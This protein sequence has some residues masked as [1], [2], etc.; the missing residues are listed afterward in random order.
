MICTCLIHSVFELLQNRIHPAITHHIG[1]M[2]TKRDRDDKS[3]LPDGHV[4]KRSRMASPPPSPKSAMKKRI[5]N[6]VL[7]V[8]PTNLAAALAISTRRSTQFFNIHEKQKMFLELVLPDMKKWT[9]QQDELIECIRILKVH[10]GLPYD[11]NEMIQD[12]RQ[13][14]K[15]FTVLI[16]G[17]EMTT[18]KLEKMAYTAIACDT[19]MILH[20]IIRHPNFKINMPPTFTPPTLKHRLLHSALKMHKSRVINVLLAHPD[21]DPNTR[22]VFGTVW[23]TGLGTAHL[24]YTHTP[25]GGDK[26]K[27]AA[28]H[29][30]ALLDRDDVDIHTLDDGRRAR[31]EVYLV[32]LKV[33]IQYFAGL[34]PSRSDDERCRECWSG[35]EFCLRRE[36]KTFVLSCYH[37]VLFSKIG[38]KAILKNP[39]E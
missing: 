9:N 10:F 25:P 21:I 29:V 23:A 4:V 2:D 1:A 7:Q 31:V 3:P 33:K 26:K 35:R 11:F 28:Q 20:S 13:Y 39:M 6:A 12:R 19:D 36:L 15:L 24:T 8:S 30:R 16:E 37:R 32:D 27:S 14:H 34:R 22:S 18:L 5:T 17:D 38:F